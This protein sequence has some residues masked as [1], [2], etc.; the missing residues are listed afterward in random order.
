M[1]TGLPDSVSFGLV[2]TVR[3]RIN[4]FSYSPDVDTGVYV[5]FLS[6]SGPGIAAAIGF[7]A[8]NNIPYVKIQDVNANVAVARIP[9]DWSDG[10]FHTYRVIRDPRTDSLTLSIDS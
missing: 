8:L 4:S 5:G 9:F 6:N 10:Q 7:D 3:L 1:K 2:F